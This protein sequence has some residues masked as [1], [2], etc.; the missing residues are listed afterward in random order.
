MSTPAIKI[1]PVSAASSPAISRRT[2]VLPDPEAPS[3]V[4]N[5]PSRTSSDT[6]STAATF[7]KDLETDLSST[8]Q[9]GAPGRSALVMAAAGRDG[10]A[11]GQ[12]RGGDVLQ[13]S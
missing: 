7:P 11:P 8:M 3:S 5:S 9:P 10:S 13:A 4:K 2:V 1:S 12:P 6:S